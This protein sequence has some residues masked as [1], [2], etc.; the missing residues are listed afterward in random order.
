[1]SKLFLT[2][3]WGFQP[4][5]YPLLGF[6]TEG[7]RRKFLR[8]SEP[9]DWVVL[10]GTREAPTAVENR[11]RLLGMVQLGSEQVDVEE[12]L[13][14]IGSQ[15]SDDQYH[16]DGTY[17]WPFGLPMIEALRFPDRPDLAETLGSYLSGPQ[18]A[19]YALDVTDVLGDDARTKLLALPTEPV[20]IGEAPTI[21]RQRDKQNALVLNRATGLTGPA[22]S[23]TRAE[24]EGS[25]SA[26]STYLLELQGK[27]DVWKV[28]YSADL[29]ERLMTLN[30]G[31]VPGVTGYSWKLVLIQ[32]FPTKDQAF[33]FEQ[34]LHERL[35]PH[36]V[37][38][39]REVYAMPSGDVK[40]IWVDV[41]K[42]ADWAG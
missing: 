32:K 9:G 4:E 6:G 5:D 2:K 31:L 30:R 15:I 38:G 42:R 18:W 7:G 39:D 20:A 10:A 17:R 21:I 3:V 28:G 11:G 25:D 41:F 34:A 23:N 1:M 12:V 19:A 16:A 33:R 37:E 24:S 29:H 35:H 36:H 26:A 8:E 14:L 27:Q 40:H 13:S 22:P